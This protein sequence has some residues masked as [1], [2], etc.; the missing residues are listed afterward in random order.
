MHAYLHTN[1]HTY[2]HTC[3]LLILMFWHRQAIF[4]SKGSKLSSSAECRFRSWEVWYTKSTYIRTYR[5][6]NMHWYTHACIHTYNH[7][8]I[9]TCVRMY[10][11]ICTWTPW[12]N[13]PS[14]SL[15]PSLCGWWGWIS[16]RVTIKQCL[17]CEYFVS[18]CT[19]RKQFSTAGI[20]Q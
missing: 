17:I 13:I 20:E 12:T 3:L 5:H 11:C 14:Y 9:G 19:N 2:I 6:T 7:K 4:E 1:R 15:L 16:I 10:I 18:V 8:Y